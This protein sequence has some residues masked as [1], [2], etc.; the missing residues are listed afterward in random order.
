MHLFATDQMD[1]PG[2]PMPS[3]SATPEVTCGIVTGTHIGY[4][5]CWR[6]AGNAE[7]EC[8]DAVSTLVGDPTLKG[9][10]IDFR[11]N[12]GGNMGLSD[13]GLQL[14][15][16]DSTKTICFSKRSDPGNHFSMNVVVPASGYVIPGNGIGYDKPIAVLVGPGAVSSGDQVA[17]RMTFH[18][19]VRTFGKSTNTAFNAP[20]ALSV[21]I[22][23]YAFYAPYETCLASDT[24]YFLT[25]REFPVDVPVWHTRDAVAHGQDAVVEA[26]EEWINSAGRFVTSSGIVIQ[27]V[28]RLPDRPS[29]GAGYLLDVSGRRVI[30][31]QPGANDVSRLSAGVYFM[32]EGLNGKRATAGVRKVVIAR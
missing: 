23:W 4:I 7:H 24:T 9:I 6:W 1:V 31:L 21:P 22:G 27:D 15:F 10:I 19:R 32:R 11:Y 20:T 8:Y 26:A 28:L 2:V 18:P 16:R 30:E 25:H 3:T 14:L 17:F 12:E 29:A 5:Y 13:S